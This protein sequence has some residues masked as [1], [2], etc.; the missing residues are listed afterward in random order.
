MFCN[1]LGIQSNT[2]YAVFRIVISIGIQYVAISDGRFS[3]SWIVWFNDILH[4]N[5]DTML[6][7]TGN[8]GQLIK[9]LAKSQVELTELQTEAWLHQ[10]LASIWCLF[11][12]LIANDAS[13]WE[14]KNIY[15]SSFCSWFGNEGVH[16]LRD[17]PLPWTGN[18]YHID[19]K[20]CI[21]YA[22]WYQYMGHD[23]WSRLE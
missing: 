18:T 14:I 13:L 1:T 8:H 10:H 15:P 5:Q 19:H 9:N 21:W 3:F 11:Q 2:L 4:Y 7:W 6:L 12:C 22:I 16:V 17:L 20:Q 23:L